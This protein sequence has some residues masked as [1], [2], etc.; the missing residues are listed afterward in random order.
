MILTGAAA[1]VPPRA[2]AYQNF[3]HFT[4]LRSS[5]LAT[6][7]SRTR[8][9]VCSPPATYA[10]R[11]STDGVSRSTSSSSAPTGPAQSLIGRADERM[12]RER[13]VAAGQRAELLVV[14][15]TARPAGPVDQ[16]RGPGETRLREVDQDRAD[17]HD[18]DLFGHEERLARLGRRQHE[19]AQGP[20]EAHLVSRREGAEPRGPEARGG[21]VGGQRDG[22]SRAG[23]GGDGVG[24]HGLGAE[25][26]R[27]P[28]AGLERELRRLLHP[29]RRLQDVGRQ[30]ADGRDARAALP[31]LLHGI[32]RHG[33]LRAPPKPPVA[34]VAP[35]GTRGAPRA[36]R[37]LDSRT[38]RR[39]GSTSAAKSLE[40]LALLLARPR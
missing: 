33:G 13:R 24:A 36:R 2:R 16:P 22:L 28:L 38:P 9:I 15:Q 37:A 19:A 27:D 34:L 21:H 14:H 40:L 10:T 23:R 39:R 26:D 12:I 6:S 4:A 29:E 1:P 35:R 25:G 5:P 32:R 31:W 17:G 3:S 30:L 18:A 11:F 7:R 20:L 8:W